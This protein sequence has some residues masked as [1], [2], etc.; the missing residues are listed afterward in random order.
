MLW[1]PQVHRKFVVTHRFERGG[2]R[3]D[4]SCS[5]LG[6]RVLE[7]RDLI[8]SGVRAPW[9]EVRD[10]VQ[11]CQYVILV[12][13]IVDVRMRDEESDPVYPKFQIRCLTLL[14]PEFGPRER[15][16]AVIAALLRLWLRDSCYLA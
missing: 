9:L 3:D 12:A 14:S 5:H 4:D 6:A 1:P 11:C 10:R 8:A 7:E 13:M 15:N 16:V 2:D